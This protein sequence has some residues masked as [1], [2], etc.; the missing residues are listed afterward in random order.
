MAITAAR[1]HVL[2]GV[3]LIR[4]IVGGIV[5]FFST[6]RA[7]QCYEKTDSYTC[8]NDCNCVWCKNSCYTSSTAPCDNTFPG[9]CSREDAEVS[10]YRLI[11]SIVAAVLGAC[12]G[13]SWCIFCCVSSK[14]K[15][16]ANYTGVA[17]NDPSLQN[18]QA[19]QAFMAAQQSQVP[20][21]ASPFAGQPMMMTAVTGPDG[22]PQY[23][24]SQV[25]SHVMA[26]NQQQQQQL[27]PQ[28]YV[29]SYQ[30]VYM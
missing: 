11:V 10:T 13:I 30:P 1:A 29:V 18:P 26:S 9:N 7:K 16:N 17:Q 5:L 4:I 3:F 6:P 25:P 12:V 8:N 22:Q 28:Q 23:I 20:T 21:F 19:T 14:P 15:P 27:P 24:L 2:F